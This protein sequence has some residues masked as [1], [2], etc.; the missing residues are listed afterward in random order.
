MFF[1]AETLIKRAEARVHLLTQR[2]AAENAHL[3]AALQREIRAL[4]R[5]INNEL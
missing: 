4:Q 1:S 3:I 2:D 5:K